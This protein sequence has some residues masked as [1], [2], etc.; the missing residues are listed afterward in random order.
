MEITCPRKEFLTL[1]NLISSFASTRDL[2]PILQNVKAV[3]NEKNILLT[4]TDGEVGARGVLPLGDGFTLLASGEALLPP[5]LLKKILSETTSNDVTLKYENSKLSVR[6][7]HSKYQL[8]TNGEMSAFPA[9]A[10]FANGAYVKVPA[11][12]LCEVIRRTAFATDANSTHY[13]L[14]GVKFI[15]REDRLEAV[16]T[17]ARRLARQVCPAELCGAQEFDGEYA[18]EALFAPRALNLIE[19][20]ANGVDDVLIAIHDS[21]AVVKAGDVVISTKLLVG[22]FPDWQMIIPDR[23]AKKRV[24]FIAGE[25]AS[26]I[27]QAEI[28]VTENNPGVWFNFSEG[29]V[30]IAAAGEATGESSVV[31]PIAY[32]GEAHKLRLDSRFLNEFFRCVPPEETIAF[33]FFGDFRTLLETTDGYQ[34]VVMQMA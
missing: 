23:T 3:V 18:Q 1:F 31:L 12:S 21:E 19:R 33:Y 30:D 6:C 32:S 34:Y 16:A 26:A 15:F 14:R 4:A 28:V 13:E 9:L 10:D 17:D 20:A 27:R 7:G 24:D 25:L 8:D 5:K 2:R 29:S 22:R 11:K